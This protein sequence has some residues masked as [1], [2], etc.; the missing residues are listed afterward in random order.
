ML[1]IK[2]CII[3]T[4]QCVCTLCVC[5]CVCV[6]AYACLSVC[7]CVVYEDFCKCKD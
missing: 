6:R 3:I 1:V 2:Q 7:V 5:V 4:N